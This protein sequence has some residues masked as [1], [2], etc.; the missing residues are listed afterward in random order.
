MKLMEN[1]EE[2]I[3]K[4]SNDKIKDDEKAKPSENEK[5]VEKEETIEEKLKS[6]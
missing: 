6:V 4:E 3:L 2:K 5:L 1:T